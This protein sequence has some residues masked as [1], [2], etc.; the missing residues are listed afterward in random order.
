MAYCRPPAAAPTNQVMTFSSNVAPTANALTNT[1]CAIGS[2]LLG[3]IAAITPSLAAGTD[4]IVFAYMNLINTLNI[5][6]KNLYITG[7]TVQGVVTTILANAVTYEY[8]IAFG[9]TVV[10]MVNNEVAFDH[11]PRFVPL[12]IESFAIPVGSLGSQGINVL[13]ET[14]IVIRPREYIHLIARNITAASATGTIT[15]IAQFNGYWD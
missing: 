8:S 4:G 6:G 14:P 5:T 11:A 10:S 1:T 3:G 12:G 9:D 15:L 2:T 13:F 7:V